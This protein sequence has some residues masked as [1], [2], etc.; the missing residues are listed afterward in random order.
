MLVWRALIQAALEVARERLSKE[1]PRLRRRTRVV[2][3]SATKT[4]FDE[5]EL[6]DFSMALF[7]AFKELR[8]LPESRAVDQYLRSHP[9][10]EAQI[11]VDAAGKAIV[12]EGPRLHWLTNFYTLPFTLR[13]MGAVGD[14]Q[15]DESKFSEMYR[16]LE[17]FIS[18]TEITYKTIAPLQNFDGP[19]KPLRL[20]S[21]TL[22]RPVTDDELQR[23]WD[24]GEYGGMVDR[25]SALRWRFCLEI[26]QKQRKNSDVDAGTTVRTARNVLTALRLV[27]NGAVGIPV[28]LRWAV[29]KPYGSPGGTIGTSGPSLLRFGSTYKLSPGD[30]DSLLRVVKATAKVRDKSALRVALDRFNYAY[31]RGRLHDRVIDEWVALEALFLP[32]QE[33]ELRFRAAL[34]I[35]YFAGRDVQDRSR[36]YKLMKD[37]Y[38]LRSWIVH[39]ES[40]PKKG[41]SAWPPKRVG[42]VAAATEE[43]VREILRLCVLNLG[44]PRVDRLD[45]AIVAGETYLLKEHP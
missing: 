30:A 35:S 23:V 3:E 26:T 31:D 29:D 38:D 40:E 17:G 45:A 37:S 2:R 9:D 25:D 21:M 19:A 41:K 44:E 24:A 15:Y 1:G 39:G 14:V 7:R 10:F 42:E 27:R 12:A 16:Q 6:P 11:M 36:L 32:T 43:S 33:Q 20:D 22:L 28:M 8:N 4:R 18:Q 5:E 13:Y 34:R